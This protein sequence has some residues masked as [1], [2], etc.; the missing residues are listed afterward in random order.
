MRVAIRAQD[1]VIGGSIS[2]AW[3]A[4][5]K[6]VVQGGI[7]QCMCQCLNIDDGDHLIAAG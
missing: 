1:V 5:R 6:H 4:V 2:A 3:V 7:A